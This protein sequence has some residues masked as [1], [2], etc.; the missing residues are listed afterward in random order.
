MLGIT[1]ISLNSYLT[2][3]HVN[4]QIYI[5]EFFIHYLPDLGTRVG[6]TVVSVVISMRVA[7]IVQSHIERVLMNLKENA[8]RH[9]DIQ[10]ENKFVET[11]FVT[12]N[13][14]QINT[15]RLFVLVI[16]IWMIPIPYLIFTYL[17]II[18]KIYLI[19]TIGLL[20]AKSMSFLV[21]VFIVMVK[22]YASIETLHAIIA[23]TKILPSK[24]VIFIR[25]M[26]R[27]ISQQ[28]STWISAFVENNRAYSQQIRQ[29][30]HET[31]S[32]KKALP[33]QEGSFETADESIIPADT[34]HEQTL[35]DETALDVEEIFE[36]FNIAEEFIPLSQ[37]S[38]EPEPVQAKT[39]HKEKGALLDDLDDILSQGT[40]LEK[41]PTN[42][43]GLVKQLLTYTT[44]FVTG[45]LLTH[46]L[47]DVLPP[48]IY[49]IALTVLNIY[50]IFSVGGILL[51]MSPML[52]D[53][54]H[55]LHIPFRGFPTAQVSQVIKPALLTDKL[56]NMLD[57]HVHYLEKAVQF[58]HGFISLLSWFWQYIINISHELIPIV[59]R[60]ATY[61]I[62]AAVVNLTTQQLVP[63]LLPTTINTI[64]IV[65]NMF[66]ILSLGW[67]LIKA[68]MIITHELDNIS[69]NY[70][71][72]ARQRSFYGYMQ[73]SVPAFNILLDYVLKIS[74]GIM[75]LLRQAVVYT[76]Y[77]TVCYLTTQQLVTTFSADVTYLL[78][79]AIKV[80]LI[81]AIGHV[82]T[83]ATN[84]II[85]GMSEL[86]HEY[87][88][89]RFNIEELHDKI[90]ILLP[91]LKSTLKYLIYTTAGILAINQVDF[92][93]EYIDYT[94]LLV[95]VL[96]IYFGS[97]VMVESVDLVIHKQLLAHDDLADD[98]LWQQRLTMA[99]LISSA[100]RYAIYFATSLYI[101]H[102]L[103]YD[104][105]IIL[106]GL[107]GIGLVVGL[108]AQPVVTDLVSGAFVLF[109][110]L[111]LV[112]DYIETGNAK[113]IVEAIDIRT[114][115]LR[116]PD[117]QL[118]I[119]RNGQIGDI[120]N[121]S[122]GYVFAVVEI[123]VSDELDMDYVYKILEEAGRR[124]KDCNEAVL[125]PTVV[126]G[127]ES[128]GESEMI[129][130]TVTKTK[131][132]S[133]DE[134]SRELRRLFKEI[135]DEKNISMPMIERAFVVKSVE[136][137][138][139]KKIPTSVVSFLSMSSLAINRK[140]AINIAQG[141]RKRY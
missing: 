88:K 74:G 57:E 69:E 104:I 58:W 123:G 46:Q 47:I 20:I 52:V 77:A 53:N 102:T 130:R 32:Q 3:Q 11:F 134:V 31:V 45:T 100:S 8:K 94:I 83:K 89:Q 118:H 76:M 22:K 98:I 60:T 126:E 56:Y 72:F 86:S 103:G 113:G 79:T 82:L 40:E 5:L 138:E 30:L 114:T 1:A 39:H 34:L 28:L 23:W 68:I 4:L 133:H 2:H 7:R 43:L 99:P 71:K 9:D 96:A 55:K 106:A 50:L 90:V 16:A 12:L 132:G 64:F 115:R 37:I 137:H 17:F 141:H 109:E 117:G 70:L 15:I 78:F 84:I 129:I 140:R 95:K 87:I 91:V 66:L 122:K 112:G 13:K 120:I 101:L 127:I 105:T 25:R 48:Y 97:R 63:F 44:Y 33:P 36:T 124:L 93:K 92:L 81:M 136:E 18:L 41:I 75:L 38:A 6:L 108:G 59:K 128:F 119:I 24:I 139:H 51:K 131:P 121:Y 111:Y 62:C 85:D 135:F 21:D 110:N 67:L 42:F 125:E 65:I 29:Q 10:Q 26:P 80:G 35:T 73:K 14:I 116:N 107:G 54:F 27:H 19:V 49:E 61:I